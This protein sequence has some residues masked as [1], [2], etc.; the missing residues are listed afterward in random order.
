MA[1]PNRVRCLEIMSSLI[2]PTL[3]WSSM[4]LSPARSA[5]AMSTLAMLI[6]VDF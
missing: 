3:P 6:Y 4:R 5:P 2:Q 1:L